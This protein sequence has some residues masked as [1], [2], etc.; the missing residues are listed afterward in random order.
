MIHQ[1][2]YNDS[3]EHTSDMTCECNPVEFELDDGSVIISHFSLDGREQCEEVGIDHPNIWDYY[4]YD[5]ESGWSD[6]EDDATD[7][8]GFGIN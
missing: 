8:L 7:N 5:D 3:I 1:I 2:P 6:R 4:H